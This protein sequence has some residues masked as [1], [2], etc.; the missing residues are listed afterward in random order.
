M[1]DHRPPLIV[2]ATPNVCWLDPS[3]KFP[4]TPEDM[5]VEARRCAEAGASILHMHADDWPPAIQAV[6]DACDLIVQCGM[7]SRTPEERREVF[8][9][10][11]DM[12]SII[13]SHHDEA[14]V[15]LDVHK[16]HPR[17]ELQEY[18]RLQ[19]ESDVR[20][21][22]EIWHTGAIWNLEWL[23]EHA[24]LEPPYFTSIFF[25]W[26]G[27]SWSPPTV[28][29]YA[30]RRRHLP[31]GSVATVSI[32]DPRQ[33][34]IVSA[35]INAGDHVRVGTEDYPRGRDGEL[36]PTHQLVAEVVELAGNLGREIA[37][38]AQARELTGVRSLESTR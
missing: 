22:Y 2:T 28:E 12:I 25:G 23:I 27:G 11:A 38:P 1:T 16:L 9:Q 5:A 37:T 33:I 6:R 30:Y 34:D 32:M 18:A 36:A 20:L 21:E 19:A 8:A 24:S 10:K 7:S 13:T 31:A 26:P 35:A 4:V 15:G 3:V 14:F 17:E 29:E